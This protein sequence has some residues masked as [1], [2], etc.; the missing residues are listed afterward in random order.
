MNP[1]NSSPPLNRLHHRPCYTFYPSCT[2]EALYRLYPA[3]RVIA[4]PVLSRLPFPAS[5]LSYRLELIRLLGVC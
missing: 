5:Q 1:M 3:P 4:V 2:F